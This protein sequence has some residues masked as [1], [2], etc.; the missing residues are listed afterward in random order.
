MSNPNDNPLYKTLRETE[1]MTDEQIDALL[2]KLRQM[3]QPSVAAPP[4]AKPCTFAP[5]YYRVIAGSFITIVDA[6]DL[7]QPH[8]AV[9]AAEFAES[10]RLQAW[11]LKDETKVVTFSEAITHD[12]YVEWLRR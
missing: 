11:Y 7:P 8:D 1:S 12:E 3:T 5:V 6:R 4:Q 2:D 10:N 9:Y